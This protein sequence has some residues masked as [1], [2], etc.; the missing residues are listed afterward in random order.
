VSGLNG[1]TEDCCDGGPL[2]AAAAA[3][4][5]AG[6]PEG[7]EGVELEEM[8]IVTASSSSA[9]AAEGLAGVRKAG[10]CHMFSCCS[11]MAEGIELDATVDAVWAYEWVA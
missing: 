1:D 9:A 7:V 6:A 10:C 11:M 3:A 4:E 2:A 5:A 8:L